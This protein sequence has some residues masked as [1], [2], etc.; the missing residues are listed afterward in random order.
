MNGQN[1]STTFSV[2]QSPEE[3]FAAIN[4]VRGWWSEE[5]EGS[6]DRPGAEFHYH[7]QDVHRCTLKISEFIPNEKVVWH[8]VDN[9]FSFTQDKSEWKGTNISFEISKKGARTEIHF[10]HLGLVP[11]YECFNVCSE[12]WGTYINGSLHALITTGKGRP[13]IGQAI[14]QGEQAL[15]VASFTTA[16]L[17]DRT[18]DEVYAA[19]NNVRGWWAGEIEGN[20]AQLGEEFTYRYAD[21]HRS[22]QKI[23]LL[24]PGKE[25]VWHVVD[26]QL[27]FTQ[28]K[29]EWTGT[30][31]TFELAKKGAQTEVRFTHVGLVPQLE[32]FDACSNAW[33]TL[34]HENLR[35]LI[36]APLSQP[37][38]TER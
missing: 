18:P 36:T 25:V 11:E 2:E 4:N 6:T 12:A 31:I 14:T 13:N 21:V 15:G 23:A 38:E 19:I 34:I 8:V 37:A 17:V 33:N 30:N 20:T 28:D 10:S 9:Y 24:V 35:D 7:F 3:A 26:A 22:K 5:I 27:N 32:C 16:F 29:S 1:F